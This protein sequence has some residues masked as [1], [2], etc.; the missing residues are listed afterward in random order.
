MI[1][2]FFGEYLPVDFISSYTQHRTRGN[3]AVGGDGEG[4]WTLS[5]TLAE[6]GEKNCKDVLECLLKPKIP[7]FIKM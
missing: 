5:H 6:V 7:K 2:I 3:Q 1:S 4:A